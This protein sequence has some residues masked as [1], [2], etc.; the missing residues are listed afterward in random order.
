M[1]GNPSAKGAYVIAGDATADAAIFATGSEVAIAVASLELLKA[2]GI[3]AKVI[4]VPSMELFAEQSADYRAE[5]IGAP[6]AKV[7]IEAGLEMSW[8]KLLGDKGR[9]VGMHGFG[10]SAPADKLYEHFG[11]TAEAILEAVM[12][13]L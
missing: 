13:Q 5:V 8:S 4:S 7:A 6:K 3:S 11:I 2:Q 10:A 1:S 9:F 12:A